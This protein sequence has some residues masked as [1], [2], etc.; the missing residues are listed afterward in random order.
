MSA[1]QCQVSC[2]N[3]RLKIKRTFWGIGDF[4]RCRLH[5]LVN[6]SGKHLGWNGTGQDLWTHGSTISKQYWAGVWRPHHLQAG[7]THYVFLSY[8]PIVSVMHLR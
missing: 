5:I 4:Y 8:S 6:L 7:L 3:D 2:R 1:E